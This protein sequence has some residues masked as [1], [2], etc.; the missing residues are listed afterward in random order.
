MT[1]GANITIETVNDALTISATDT[2]VPN[3]SGAAGYVASAQ[4]QA[5]KAWMTD[6]NGNPAWRDVSAPTDAQ[7]RT[8]VYSYLDNEDIEEMVQT[9]G[10]AMTADIK[11]A[12]LDALAHVAWADAS[13]MTYYN[14]LEAALFPPLNLISISAV[15]TPTKSIYA[16]DSLDELRS[17][18]VVTANYS[19]NTTETITAYTLTGTLIAGT[20]TITVTYRGKTAT[21]QVT[22]VVSEELW[23]N[24]LG[25]T[26]R[27]S[28]STYAPFVLP[29]STYQYDYSKPIRAIEL[30]FDSAGTLSVGYCK[31][32]TPS[33][34]Y[35]A[36]DVVVCETLSVSTT[37]V[38]KL[39]LQTPL[40]IPQNGA[41][42]I[43]A[44]NDSAK[45]YYG[46]TL[47]NGFIYHNSDGTWA[48]QSLTLGINVYR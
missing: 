14:T 48:P 41:L 16:G 20:R 44:Q 31:K 23:I 46:G 17:D 37:G 13:G 8:A 33:G 12:L 42:L 6:G 2:W 15:Y 34:T 26:A 29:T 28:N 43:G 3:S 7:V 4:G 1:A 18:L 47:T 38:H 21:F 39:S 27:I 45:F 30:D 9:I 5:N 22:V 10:G 40:T 25:S 19:D 35:R 36:S 32:G 24:H 11:Q